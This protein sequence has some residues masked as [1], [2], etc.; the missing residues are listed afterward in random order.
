MTPLMTSTNTQAMCFLIATS[1]W[2]PQSHLLV[3]SDTTGN[4]DAD[5][6][7]TTPQVYPSKEHW[8]HTPAQPWVSWEAGEYL[9]TF[10]YHDLSSVIMTPQML[11]PPAL[12]P[13][14]LAI[15]IRIGSVLDSWGFYLQLC[16]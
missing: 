15:V 13:Q 3:G 14:I 10:M 12:E 16:L 9:E 2:D 7:R 1:E 11:K 8:I 5:S 6:P 4:T